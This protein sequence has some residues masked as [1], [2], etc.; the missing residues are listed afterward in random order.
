MGNFKKIFKKIYREIT[1]GCLSSNW[2][3]FRLPTLLIRGLFCSVI[4][5]KNNGVFIMKEDWDNLII[6]DACRYDMFVKVNWIEGKLEKKISRGSHTWMFLKE[7]FKGRTYLD[8][9]Y[10]SSNP[11]ILDFQDSFHKVIY[12][13]PEEELERY[14]TVLPETVFAEALKAQ[15]DYPHKRLII[16][17]LQPHDPFI[18][19]TR[20]NKEDNPF[21]MLAKGKIGKEHLMKAYED[22]LKAVLIYVEKLLKELSGKTIITSDHGESFGAKVKFF[23]VRIYGHSGPRIKELIEVPWLTVEKYPRKKI[24]I[25][26]KSSFI[27]E[28]DDN[29]IY[30]HL[31][32]LGY[33]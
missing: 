18:G 12:V 4:R 22:N 28:F 24:I 5:E 23:P 20:F 14:G 10:V 17:F 26:E 8:T 9:V 30:K 31:Q 13:A 25:G 15:K 7:N 3:R 29:K 19:E 6:L 2:W 11:F 21:Y 32:A 27:E 1:K 33:I 16:H